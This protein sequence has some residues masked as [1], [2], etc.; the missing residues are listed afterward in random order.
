VKRLTPK[1]ARIVRHLAYHGIVHAVSQERYT[2]LKLWLQRLHGAIF[3]VGSLLLG[4]AIASM[5]GPKGPAAET[6]TDTWFR[7]FHRFT[8]LGRVCGGGLRLRLVVNDV[9]GEA[10][11][12]SAL[13]A[14]KARTMIQSIKSRCLVKDRV[15][16]ESRMRCL[17]C[18]EIARIIAVAE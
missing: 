16:C 15:L 1:A 7:F 9:G 13:A 5:T 12:S 2:A 3:A 14:M 11:V 6:R 10:P 17:Q 8:R 18:A 4:I